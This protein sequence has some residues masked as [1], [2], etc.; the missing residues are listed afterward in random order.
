MPESESLPA[1]NRSVALPEND[2]LPDI[3]AFF[4][5]NHFQVELHDEPPPE[6]TPDEWRSKSRSERQARKAFRPLYWADLKRV[7]T[8]KLVRWYGGGDSPE[9][10]LRS[11]RSRWRV[12]QGD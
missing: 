2:P 7:E 12:E 3:E 6:P 5:Q 9:A 8:G 1:H 4:A 11:A 10:A